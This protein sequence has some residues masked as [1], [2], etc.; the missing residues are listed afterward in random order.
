MAAHGPLGS[1]RRAADWSCRRERRSAQKKAGPTTRQEHPVKGRAVQGQG[2]R[3]PG[4]KS[5]A[6][7]L[8]RLRV[9]DVTDTEV[10]ATSRSNRTRRAKEIKTRYPAKLLAKNLPFQPFPQLRRVA[11]EPACASR[12]APFRSAAPHFATAHRLRM[13]GPMACWPRHRMRRPPAWKTLGLSSGQT[14]R[15]RGGRAFS[16]D[17]PDRKNTGKQAQT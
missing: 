14:R 5:E 8:H 1:Y 17:R 16:T 3:T 12:R 6:P 2:D 9:W 7:P 10:A 15:K 4:I 11:P 13:A